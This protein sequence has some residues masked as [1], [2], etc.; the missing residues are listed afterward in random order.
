M[1]CWVTMYIFKSKMAFKELDAKFRA[2][3]RIDIFKKN[4]IFHHNFYGR[5]NEDRMRIS[6]GNIFNTR[7]NPIMFYAKIL[8]R[9]DCTIIKGHFGYASPEK[10]MPILI[11]AACLIP[12]IFGA[13]NYAMAII[14]ASFFLVLHCLGYF[15]WNLILPS[16]KKDILSFIENELGCERI[17]KIKD[18]M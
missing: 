3:V 5:I 7:H 6:T 4:F 12:M 14:V 13:A 2:L 10:Y 15:I 8:K 16:Y 17:K 18:I 1:R 11:A 9:D